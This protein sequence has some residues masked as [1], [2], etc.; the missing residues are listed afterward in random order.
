ME[1]ATTISNSITVSAENVRYDA[2]CK[3]LLA[4]K[5]ILAWIMKCT[6]AEF[7]AV[8]VQDI[9]EKYIVGTPQVAEM[10]IL[11]DETNA[12]RINGTGV[13]D[14]T[15]TEGTVTFDIRFYAILPTIGERVGLI[16]NVEAQN[17]FFPG[18]PLIKRAIYYCCRM[19]S[20]QY[21]TEFTK[22]HYEKIKKVYSIWICSN[23]TKIRENTITEYGISERNIWGDVH[24]D[25]AD[26]DLLTAIMI[27][28]GKPED[29]EEKGILRLLDV[30]LS[31]E[32]D[33]N[34]KK[35]ILENDF[36]IAMTEQFERRIVNMCNL[37]E[38]VFQKGVEQGIERQL[39]SSIRLVMESLN[40]S[41][42]QAMDVFKLNSEEKKKYAAMI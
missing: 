22:F 40:Y 5:I 3:E 36:N 8:S 4:E 41:V 10:P 34:T 23:P 2:A 7:S 24:E 14:T 15:I 13:E 21:G 6:M 20:S 16:I 19:V 32:I 18:Y 30:L 31:G 1:K 17:D 42:D 27:C 26:Y 12:P 37:S 39:I 29:T 33:T 38:G 35:R 28:L 9:V 11:P 25:V